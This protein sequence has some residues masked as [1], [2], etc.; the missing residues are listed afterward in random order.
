MIFVKY[1]GKNMREVST[2][3][4]RDKREARNYRPVHNINMNYFYSSSALYSYALYLH[5]QVHITWFDRE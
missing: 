1:K 2:R 5:A 4:F 3:P